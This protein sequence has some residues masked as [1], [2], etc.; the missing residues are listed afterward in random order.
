M[1]RLYRRLFIP[2]CH[3]PEVDMRAWAVMLDVAS[4][5]KP[6]EVVYLGDFH[7]VYSCSD[8]TKDPLKNINLLRHELE[9]GQ[10]AMAQVEKITKAKSFVFLEGNHENRIER[11]VATYASKLA[12]ITSTRDILGIP[13]H[14]KYYPYGMKNHHHMGKLVATHGSVCGQHAAAAMLRKYGQSVVFGHTHRTQEYRT[15]NLKGEEFAAFNIGWLGDATKAAEYIKNVP[16]WSHG[17]GIAHFKTSGDFFFQ[18]ISISP[19]G[20]CLYHG[21]L[22]K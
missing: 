11:Y 8:Y 15:R 13:R 9:P 12:G 19:Q 21:E 10:A 20:E 6:D 4:Q 3:F 5:F 2:D 14:Y 18:T 7:D 1:I 17:F 16:D 22:V